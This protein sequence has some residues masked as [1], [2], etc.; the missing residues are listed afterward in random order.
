MDRINSVTNE[1]ITI[2]GLILTSSS[3]KAIYT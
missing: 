3:L 2:I 1:S